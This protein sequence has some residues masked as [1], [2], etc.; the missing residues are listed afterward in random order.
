MSLDD[1]YISQKSFNLNALEFVVGV[2]LRNYLK[3]PAS[4]RP[5]DP[6]ETIVNTQVH[7][8]IYHATFTRWLLYPGFHRC[9]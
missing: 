1:L 5:H 2:Q 6:V 8:S 3:F 9:D 7:L 4:L